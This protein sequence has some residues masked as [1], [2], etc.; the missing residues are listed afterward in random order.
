MYRIVG[1]A[2]QPLVGVD[3]GIVDLYATADEFARASTIFTRA[4]REA[5]AE[6]RDWH[7]HWWEI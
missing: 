4:T 1:A 3:L 5:L 6:A 2:V 7:R